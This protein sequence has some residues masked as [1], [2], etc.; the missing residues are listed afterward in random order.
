MSAK[1]KILLLDDVKC[2]GRSGDTATVARGYANYLIMNKRALIADRISI[3]RQER[4]RQERQERAEQELSEE[5]SLV[6]RLDGVSLSV[7]VKV[8]QDGHMYGSVSSKDISCK[9]EALGFEIDKK[10]IVLQKPIKEIGETTI[11]IKFGQ[12]ETVIHLS[13]L[14][15]EE[16]EG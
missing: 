2:L 12:L 4:L 8:D 11:P 6:E 7:Y 15:E 9:L 16:E 3:R 5:R 10:C 1:K 14:P 13:V